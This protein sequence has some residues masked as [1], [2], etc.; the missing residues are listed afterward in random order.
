MN[1]KDQMEEIKKNITKI[2][3][4]SYGDTHI[5]NGKEHGTMTVEY[6]GIKGKL[7]KLE[8]HEYSSFV[9][10]SAIIWELI[11]LDEESGGEVHFKDV[12]LSD[13]RFTGATVSLI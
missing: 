6:K 9:G 3:E 10:G 5:D 4:Q 13:V 2:W 11:I 7:L 12:S 1:L 8:C